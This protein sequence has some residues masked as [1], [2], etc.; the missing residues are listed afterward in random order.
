MGAKVSQ[1]C[2]TYFRTKLQ[3]SLD[4]A[5][6]DKGLLS[7]ISIKYAHSKRIEILLQRE[8]E[9]VNYSCEI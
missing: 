6:L 1:K 7:N 2:F 5:T 4:S 3:S 9:K 8:K